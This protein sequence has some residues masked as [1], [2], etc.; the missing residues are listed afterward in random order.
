MIWISIKPKILRI[1]IQPLQTAQTVRNSNKKYHRLRSSSCQM[2]RLPRANW[3]IQT[4]PKFLWVKAT[5]P[6][7]L[8]DKTLI[9]Q[10]YPLIDTFSKVLPHSRNRPPVVA[11]TPLLWNKI[12]KCLCILQKIKF[13]SNRNSKIKSV[14]PCISATNDPSRS[15]E[16]QDNH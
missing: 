2:K 14:Q 5:S 7:L 9:P 11:E 15:S 12:S 16:T 4:S 3:E 6:D 8:T 1:Q 10:R 13:L